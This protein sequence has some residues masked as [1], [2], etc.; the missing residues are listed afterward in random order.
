[1]AALAERSGAT[2]AGG[3]VVSAG[4]LV[5]TVSVTGWA[6]SEADLVGRDG[7]RPGDAWA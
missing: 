7:A 6:E 2:I 4:A 5:V 3:D 1:M